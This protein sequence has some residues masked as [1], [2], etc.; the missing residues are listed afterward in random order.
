MRY[1]LRGILL[2][3]IVILALFMGTFLLSE[4]VWWKLL[5]FVLLCGVAGTLIYRL[6]G[7]VDLKRSRK[8]SEESEE[9]GTEKTE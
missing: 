7:A 8:A 3:T 2:S 5:I 4:F 6:F 1:F 9:A